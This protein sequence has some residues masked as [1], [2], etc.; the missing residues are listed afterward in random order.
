VIYRTV[1][2]KPQVEVDIFHEGLKRGDWLVLCSDGLHGLVDDAQIQQTVTTCLHPHEACEELVR[3]ANLAGGDD[4]ITVIA[5][6]LEEVGSA[7]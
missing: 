2:D 6:K 4:N 5:L 7:G 1:G 3:L